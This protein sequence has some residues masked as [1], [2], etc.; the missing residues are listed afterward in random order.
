LVRLDIAAVERVVY[1]RYN[2]RM[3]MALLETM[4]T[5]SFVGLF[6]ER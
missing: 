4:L 3:G 6:N 2:R 1:G 5:F